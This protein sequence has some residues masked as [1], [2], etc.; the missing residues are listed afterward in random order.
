M[1]ETPSSILDMALDTGMIRDVNAPHSPSGKEQKIR[2]IH[3][4]D[5]HIGTENYGLLTGNRFNNRADYFEKTH[6]HAGAGGTDTALLY[7]A[8]VDIGYTDRDIEGPDALFAKVAWLYDFDEVFN[9]TES[10]GVTAVH[11]TVWEIF[12]SF[13]TGC[14]FGCE[15]DLHE[16]QQHH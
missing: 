5:I 7:D 1:C 6:V 2:L 9:S 14:W 13:R 3:F 12:K 4:S 16:K 11:S 15:C 10:S 8:V